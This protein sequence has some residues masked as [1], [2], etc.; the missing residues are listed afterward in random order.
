MDAK[1]GRLPVNPSENLYFCDVNIAFPKNIIE[2]PSYFLVAGRVAGSLE[3]NA[4]IA[5]FASLR[6]PP[7]DVRKHASM[8]KTTHSEALQAKAGEGA[9]R[10]PS[11]KGIRTRKALIEEALRQIN[12]R[13]IDN[14]SVL[15]ITQ[16][17]GIGN[18]TF[19]YHFPN[20]D[21]LLEEVGHSVLTRLVE[22][23]E[24]VD[25]TDPAVKICRGPLLI[26]DFVA[27]NP[28]LRPIVLR[29]IEDAE[30]KFSDVRNNLRADVTFGRS[31]GR[32]SVE[33]TDLAVGFCQALIASAIK[34]LTTSDIDPER[35][36]IL[37]GVHSLAA[38][39]VPIWDAH[40]VV[41]KEWALI[42]SK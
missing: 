29:V 6:V 4:G 5:L 40:G 15:E 8:K 41:A 38:L 19:Y 21:C 39:G 22:Q 28:Q 20:M 17:L 34:G 18:A 42:S 33:D 31:V 3:A 36:A 14:T 11:R 37:T 32:F 30:G 2:K 13:G 25:Q 23:I 27:K 9:G 12:E 16:Q 24:Q 35:R 26:M 10:K 7:A 1:M